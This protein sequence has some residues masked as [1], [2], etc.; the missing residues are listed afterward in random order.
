M[1]S[2]EEYLQNLKQ[3]LQDTADSPLEEM[4]DFFTNRLHD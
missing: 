4:S 1:K 3:W 2:S